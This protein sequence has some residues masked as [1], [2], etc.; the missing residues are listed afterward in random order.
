M[1]NP[2]QSVENFGPRSSMTA[3]QF[4][5]SPPP[6][7]PNAG[8][9]RPLRP[10]KSAP[11]DRPSNGDG[12]P[13]HIPFNGVARSSPPCSVLRPSVSTSVPPSSVAS[14]STSSGH[15]PPQPSNRRMMIQMPP[16]TSSSPSAGETSQQSMS[17]QCRTANLD[18]LPSQVQVLQL[19][20]SQTK[21]HIFQS[22]K[23][24]HKTK[25][26]PSW[27][28]LKILFFQTIHRK[29]FCLKFKRNVFALALQFDFSTCLTA[30]T[31][32]ST[33]G[34][35]RTAGR[36]LRRSFTMTTSITE[37]ASEGSAI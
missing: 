8:L 32:T 34:W 17:S 26:S 19:L 23:N 33:S 14:T 37:T 20:K 2:Q 16:S 11:I 21:G 5:M 13:R 12:S 35:T 1:N 4:S 29:S 24:D 31:A 25:G 36:P 6:P 3:G 15:F 9:C 27:L 28:Q 7:A 18:L 30:T 22:F 10:M